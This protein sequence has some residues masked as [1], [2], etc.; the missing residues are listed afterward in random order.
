MSS[1][2]VLCTF[3]CYNSSARIATSQLNDLD[4]DLQILTMLESSTYLT[5]LLL[6]HVIKDTNVTIK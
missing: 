3:D 2:S 6:V 1:Q 4:N 5:A